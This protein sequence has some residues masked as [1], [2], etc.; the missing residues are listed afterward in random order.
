MVAK[1]S[2][3]NFF[4]WA[5]LELEISSAL[6]GLPFDLSDLHV[7][8]SRLLLW[9]DVVVAAGTSE[10]WNDGGV[11]GYWSRPRSLGLR[12]GDTGS[13]FTGGF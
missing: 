8:L 5:V 7:S 1:I 11:P 10:A 3:P 13:I 6:W 4:R 12:V 9:E 2:Q